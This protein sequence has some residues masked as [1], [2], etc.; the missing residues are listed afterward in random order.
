MW[1]V[2]WVKMTDRDTDDLMAAFRRLQ[3]KVNADRLEAARQIFN[4]PHASTPKF[5]SLAQL[6]AA[7]QKQRQAKKAKPVD[8]K[9]RRAQI[10]RELDIIRGVVPTPTGY[11]V[12]PGKI[13]A[14]MK[15]LNNLEGDE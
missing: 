7:L 12:E 14:L 11:R 1:K 3:D 15:E 9:Q 4:G 5:S 2:S 8:K 6:N 13:K 10:E